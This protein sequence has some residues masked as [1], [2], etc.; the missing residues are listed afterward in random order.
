MQLLSR[1][2]TTDASEED[3]EEEDEDEE[4]NWSIHS[5]D[6]NEDPTVRECIMLMFMCLSVCLSVTKSLVEEYNVPAPT[7]SENH[8]PLPPDIIVTSHD[9]T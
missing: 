7:D 8:T 2:D 3:E 5:W 6:E 4:G 1:S 9:I